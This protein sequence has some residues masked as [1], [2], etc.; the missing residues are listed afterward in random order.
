MSI[1]IEQ[2]SELALLHRGT[3]RFLWAG[4]IATLLIFVVIFMRQGVFRPTASLGFMTDSALDIN[5]GQ[6]VKIAGFR[7]GSVDQV[8]LRPDGQ[9]EVSLDIDADYLRFVTVD[10]EVVLLKEGLVGSSILE[11]IPGKQKDQPATDNAKLKFSRAEGLTAMANSLREAIMPILGDV[12]N[13][14]GTLADPQ[15]GLPATI[16]QLRETASSLNTLLKTGNQQAGE[17]GQAA[18]SALKRADQSLAQVDQTLITVNRNLPELLNKTQRIV[19]HVEKISANVQTTLPPLLQDSGAVAS[20]M[21]EIITGAKT[22]WPVKNLIEP[23][24]AG[25]MKLD[26]DPRAEVPR[27]GR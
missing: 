6:S 24:P 14:T 23:P 13:I 16:A 26:S 5:K 10:T 1:L 12:K 18:A 9:V 17:L 7:V 20:D 11:I 27:G 25:F 15:H 2:D 22:A 19:E 21:R 3:R 4:L 8:I